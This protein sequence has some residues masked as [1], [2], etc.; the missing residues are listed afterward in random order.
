MYIYYICIH[1]QHTLQELQCECDEQQVVL[2][3]LTSTSTNIID[4]L[5]SRDCPPNEITDQVTDVQE[6]FK[7]LSDTIATYQNTWTEEASQF[8]SFL[9]RLTD[10]F[11]W[12]NEFHDTLYD[13]VCVH[14]QPKASDETIARH[15]HRLEVSCVLPVCVCV[16]VRVQVDCVHTVNTHSLCIKVKLI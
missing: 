2:N 9:T 13:E 5:T 10:F 16:F 8:E 12:M 1:F 3:A 4:E 6:R 14:I 7:S 11:N 15:R